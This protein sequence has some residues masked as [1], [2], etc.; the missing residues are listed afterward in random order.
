MC[1]HC[2]ITHCRQGSQARESD[3]VGSEQDVHDEDPEADGDLLQW[4][5]ALDFEDYTR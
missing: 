3:V 2:Q 1:Q 5:D 4:S